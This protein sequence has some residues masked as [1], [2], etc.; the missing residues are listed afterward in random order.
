A[1]I[2]GLPPGGDE[3]PPV[4][5]L[6]D[7]DDPWQIDELP[8]VHD[9]DTSTGIAQIDAYSCGDIDESG[10]ERT[11]ELTLAQDTAVRVLV[12]DREGV[13]VDVHVL[14]GDAADSCVARDD[15]AI[16]TTL[17]AGTWRIVVDSWSDGA[18]AYPGG[19]LLAVVPCDVG[20]P[21]CE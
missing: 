6:G 12:L 1:L 15:T 9:G 3:L 5:G 10:P 8:F 2:D 11:Y 4:P 17:G 7:A 16:A 21:D 14:G 13:D 20:D 19:Y 18:T